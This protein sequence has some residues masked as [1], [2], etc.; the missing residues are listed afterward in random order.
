MS[1]LFKRVIDR[2]GTEAAKQ[3]GYTYYEWLGAFGPADNSRRPM[4]NEGQYR[5]EPVQGWFPSCADIGTYDDS[6]ISEQ[7]TVMLVCATAIICELKE[8]RACLENDK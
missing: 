6:P 3:L 1:K 8:L 5:G 2:L 7:S 4:H